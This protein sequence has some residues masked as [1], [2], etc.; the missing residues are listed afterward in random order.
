[1]HFSLKEASQLLHATSRPLKFVEGSLHQRSHDA[2]HGHLISAAV[3]LTVMLHSKPIYKERE[4]KGRKLPEVNGKDE[5]HKVQN[6]NVW[7]EKIKEQ[8]G[9]TAG[10]KY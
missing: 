5:D 7:E 1:M 10:F 3:S 9:G 2:A 6:G 8:Q 4:R